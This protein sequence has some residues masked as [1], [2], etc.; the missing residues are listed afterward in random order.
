MP[1]HLQ[2]VLKS[3]VQFLLVVGAIIGLS[4]QVSAH[5]SMPCAEMVDEQSEPMAGM[6]DCCPDAQTPEKSSVDM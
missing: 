4:G 6:D 3:F 1:K 5:A 2:I